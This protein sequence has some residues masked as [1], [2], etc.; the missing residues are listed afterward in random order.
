MFTETGYRLAGFT[1]TWYSVLVVVAVFVAALVAV[2]L[3]KQSGLNPE[4]VWQALIP[5]SILGLIGARLWFVFFPPQ[6]VVANGRTAAWLLTN[7]F[8]LNQ[9]GVAVWLGGLGILGGMVG[10]ILGLWLYTRWTKQPFLVWLDIT[11]VVFPLGQAIGR[12]GN[13]INQELYGPVTNLPWGLPVT[14]ETQ[15]VAPYTDLTTYP[16]ATTYFHPV[17]L[18]ECLLCVLIFVILLTS[19][20]RRSH[21]RAGTLTLIY[22]A[23]Y[24]GGR[25]LLEFWRVNVALVAN[26]NISQVVSL[27][28]ALVSL[29]LLIRMR[30][31]TLHSAS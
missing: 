8:D 18:Y 29:V 16:L 2:R 30:Q 20:L 12:L 31:P 26:V 7:F 11:A 19:W 28:L 10:G 22:L 4:R 14:I 5:A 25:F 24:G 21:L 6:S 17:F 15:R 1:F 3:A 9:G 13:G 23:L 27:A